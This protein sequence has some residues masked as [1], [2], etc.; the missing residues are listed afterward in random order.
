MNAAHRPGRLAATLV[1][2][3]LAGAGLTVAAAPAAHA[4][5][6]DAVAKLP[7]SSFSAI[8]VDSV[9]QRVFVA[10]SNTD[11]YLNKGVIAVYD[12]RGER[13]T[14]LQTPAHVSGLALSAD[15]SKLYAGLR[16][17]IQTYDTTT[18]QPAFLASTNTDTCGRE[19]AFSG[20]QLYFTTPYSQDAGACPTAQTHL[21]GIVNGVHTRTG[22]NDYGKL[23][24]EAGPGNRMLM[25]QPRNDNAAD[26]FLTVYD[27]SDGSLVRGAAPPLRRQ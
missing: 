19:L 1:A 16:E 10:D 4:A 3:A 14:T 15:S 25:G 11:Y 21:D 24:I 8:A 9:H 12:F 27:T 20:G 22:W 2:A 18:F 26:P 13:L 6:S 7:I 5:A 23:K 17:Q